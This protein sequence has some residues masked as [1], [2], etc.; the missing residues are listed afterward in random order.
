M[1]TQDLI[2]LLEDAG[3]DTHPYSGRGMFGKQCVS[4]QSDE[5]LLLVL[6]DIV[7][8]IED[9][10]QRAELLRRAQT[11]QMGTGI[12]VY[13]PFAKWPTKEKGAA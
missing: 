1:N 6:S 7:G 5:R 10:M 11:D 3:Y 2:N 12:V 9:Q 4:V 8:C 13:W